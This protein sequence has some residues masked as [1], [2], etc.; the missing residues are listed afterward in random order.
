VRGSN[1]D[2]EQSDTRIGEHSSKFRHCL[3]IIWDV[4]EDVTAVDN[5]NTIVGQLDITDIHL[6]IRVWVQ[7][8]RRQILSIKVCSEPWLKARFGSDM[9]ECGGSRKSA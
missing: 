9:Q 5:V 6:E 2:H 1:R 7:Q 4:L 3:S 8:I